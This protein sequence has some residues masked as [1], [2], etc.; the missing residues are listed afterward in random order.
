MFSYSKAKKLVAKDAWPNHVD[1]GPTLDQLASIR[2]GLS[3]RPN[4]EGGT[5]WCKDMSESWRVATH[6]YCDLW[7]KESGESFNIKV[8]DWD[9]IGEFRD[10]WLSEWLGHYGT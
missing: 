2:C 5:L 10:A 1:L 8:K 9:F 7:M 4:G 3:I 6:E